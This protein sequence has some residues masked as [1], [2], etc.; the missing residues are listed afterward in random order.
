MPD[1]V[2]VFVVSATTLMAAHQLGDHVLQSDNQAAHKADPGL[3]GWS[4]M[5]AHVGTY[6]AIATVMLLL[7]YLSLDIDLPVRGMIAGLAFSAVTHAFL[8]RRWPVRFILT[9]LGSPTFAVMQSPVNGMYVADQALHYGCLWIS[10]LLI[11]R[12]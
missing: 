8:D 2:L 7:A 1:V 9:R 12:L 3:T 6:H 4:Y 11:A 5:A 10:A